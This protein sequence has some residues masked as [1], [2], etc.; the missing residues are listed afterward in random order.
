MAESGISNFTSVFRAGERNRIRRNRLAVSCTACQRRK[1]KCDRQQPCG[2][3]EKRAEGP[4]CKFNTIGEGSSSSSSDKRTVQL[5]LNKLEEMVRTM[6]E[7]EAT[8]TTPSSISH[9]TTHSG[10]AANGPPTGEPAKVNGEEQGHSYKGATAWTNIVDSIRD[11][12]ELLDSNEDLR[13]PAD[14]DR[15]EEDDPFLNRAESITLQEILELLPSR[16]DSDLLISSYFN[17][18][19]QAIPFI[20]THQFQRKYEAF[21]KDPASAGFLWISILFSILCAGAKIARFKYEGN[22]SV[23]T[24][25]RHP[26]VYTTVSVQCLVAGQY[27][28]NKAG[29]VEAVLM[30]AHSRNVLRL[31]SDAVIWTMYGLAVRLAQRQ[32][33]HRDPHKIIPGISPFEAEMRL[34]V[35]FMIQSSDLL[36][37][38]QNGM[39]AMVWEGAC[40]APHPTN[41][42]DDDFDEDT[43]VLPPPRG[44]VDPTPILA[45]CTKAYMTPLMRVIMRHALAVELPP[46]SET[47]RLN[48][49][50]DEWFDSVPS[51]L[52]YRPIMSTSFTDPTYTILHRLMLEL[53]YRKC[54]MVL[55]RPYLSL[56]KDDPKYNDS[57]RICREACSILQNWHVELDV[58]TSPGGRMYQDRF[59]VSG[60]TLQHFLIASTIACL[61]VTESHDLNPTE[62]QHR[63]IMLHKSQEIWTR[64]G[65]EFEDARHAAKLL[66][67]VLAKV[68]T[69]STASEAETPY[70]PSAPMSR[71]IQATGQSLRISDD[72]SMA[73]DPTFTTPFPEGDY[74]INFDQLPDLDDLFSSTEALNWVSVFTQ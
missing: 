40:D 27:L 51:C 34:R 32:G 22:T 15:F 37:S 42:T 26:K 6:A 39:P 25:V 23:L 63:I 71:I 60:L 18:K 48:R 69:P 36:F 59:M 16:Q 5:K 13:H 66:R 43:Q 68:D 72:T 45:Y 28:K 12:Q 10:S 46:Y 19:F 35:W 38:F 11:L 8:S 7:K 55:N 61:D 53:V 30:H 21:L 70:P 50:L 44:S 9:G 3:C 47:M 14:D 20:H 2:A 24:T 29:S 54:Q 17:A 33:Y 52:R 62:R 31:D 1:S 64:A 4:S 58:A 41:L 67:A 49:A 73:H 57:R 74:P 65:A 56:Y